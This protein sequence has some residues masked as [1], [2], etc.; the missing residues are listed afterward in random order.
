MP[1]NNSHV[2][3]TQSSMCLPTVKDMEDF[4]ISNS[5]PYDEIWRSKGKPLAHFFIDDRAITFVSWAHTLK[6]LTDLEEL[7]IISVGEVGEVGETTSTDVKG[8]SNVSNKKD[9]KDK[10]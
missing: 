2:V 5:I 7:R 8:K 10:K 3:P 9:K 4:L 1:D 6:I